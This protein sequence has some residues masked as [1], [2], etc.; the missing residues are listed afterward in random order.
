MTPSDPTQSLSPSVSA[1]GGTQ[2]TCTPAGGAGPR[3]DKA[4]RA[5]PPPTHCLGPLRPAGQGQAEAVSPRRARGRADPT[6]GN[7]GCSQGN[8]Q[9]GSPSSGV[10]RTAESSSKA[11]SREPQFKTGSIWESPNCFG[12]SLEGEKR[13]LIPSL[14]PPTAEGEVRAQAHWSQLQK[15][16]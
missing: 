2:A 3:R 6:P 12:S 8:E 5:Q 16:T 1:P 15:F 4:A 11:A 10:L 9:V 13:Q 7:R 14:F